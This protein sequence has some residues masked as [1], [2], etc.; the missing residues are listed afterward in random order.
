MRFFFVIF[1]IFHINIS[2]KAQ[3]TQ[4]E[5][6]GIVSYLSSQNTY[7]KFITTKG[8]MIGDTLYAKFN[9]VLVPSLIVKNLSSLSVVCSS[10]TTSK[11]N[12]NDKIIAKLKSEVKK[13]ENNKTIQKDTNEIQEKSISSEKE[14]LKPHKQKLYG[15]LSISNRVNLSN[16]PAHKSYVNN[17]SVSLNVKNIANSRFSFESNILFRQENGEWDNVKNNIFN[18][19]KIY[20]LS[21]RF[22]LK[23]NSY[24]SLGRN[25][26]TNISNIGVI[27]GLQIEKSLKKF[28][29]GGFVGTRPYY[30]DYS[31]NYRLFEYGIYF[32][33]NLQTPKRS[34]QN[35]I[36][37]LEQTNN[38][39]TDRRLL[40]F[41]HSN[42]L[43]KNLNMF[44]TLELDFYKIINE[45]KQN[46]I[47][48]TNTYLSIRYRLFK[49]LTISGT[50]DSR[51]NIIYYET[52]K[53][54]LSTLLESETRQGFSLQINYNIYKNI[55]AGARGGYRFQKSDT[56]PT[57]NAYFFVAHNNIFKSQILTTL[58]ATFL[59]TSYI[60]GNIYNLRLSRG[61]ISGRMNVSMGYSFV[62]YK[63]LNTELPFI[64]HIADLNISTEIVKKLYFSINFETD[65][66]TKNK[67]Y[68]LYF[69]LKKRF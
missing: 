17:Y 6:E 5:A 40:Y 39:N 26:N 65:I 30:I 52:E 48:L 46:T 44:F 42:S 3:A 33:H 9:N 45:Q 62:D 69:Q 23:K 35:S 47:S 67:F 66:E 54:Y 59:G 63:I 16:T 50:Y 41:Q 51:K 43:L 36:A 56:K 53:S 14:K 24:I 18:G 20:N 58:S 8:I 61:F 21:L 13:Y 12:V 7:I 29:L 37:I 49:K 11:F 1:F 15:H 38:F 4:E 25:I 60:N 19:L 28:F 2:I 10:I 32:G 22:D 57:R 27:D 55:F 64:Q 68:R 31:Y 34:M